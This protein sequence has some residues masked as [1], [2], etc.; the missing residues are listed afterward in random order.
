MLSSNAP[1]RQVGRGSPSGRRGSLPQQLL[2]LI[3]N[4]GDSKVWLALKRISDVDGGSGPIAVGLNDRE[5]EGFRLV[6]RRQDL[7]LGDGDSLRSHDT[8]LNLHESQSPRS[9]LT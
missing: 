3:G 6:E 7:V 9:G 2:K 4:A 1:R 8:S 5:D